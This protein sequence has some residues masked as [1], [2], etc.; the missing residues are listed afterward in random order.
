MDSFSVNSGSW[1]TQ[2]TSGFDNPCGVATLSSRLPGTAPGAMMTWSVTVSARTGLVSLLA[3][4][5]EK[6]HPGIDHFLP[7]GVSHRLLLQRL[8]TVSQLGGLHGIHRPGVVEHRGSNAAA[9]DIHRGDVGQ[10]LSASLDLERGALPAS[11]RQDIGEVRSVLRKPSRDG[12][13]ESSQPASFGRHMISFRRPPVLM[14]SATV[15]VK[16]T[17]SPWELG[18]L[19][20]ASKPSNS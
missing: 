10:K 15:G 20:S 17:S 3:L 1:P 9:G 12:R 19:P 5:S 8:H 2:K 4:K 18:S 7:D 11:G 6:L 14:P 16:R 13:Q